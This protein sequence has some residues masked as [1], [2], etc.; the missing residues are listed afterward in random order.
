ML[1]RS[2]GPAARGDWATIARHLEALDPAEADAYR[3]MARAARRLVDE[4]GLPDDL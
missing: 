2:T 3:A 4:N 1:F